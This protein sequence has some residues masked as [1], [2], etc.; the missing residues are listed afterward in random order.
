MEHT[1]TCHS[2]HR[3]S[4]QQCERSHSLDR[5]THTKC[6]REKSCVKH[7]TKIAVEPHRRRLARHERPERHAHCRVR[8][9]GVPVLHVQPLRARLHQLR[10][11]VQE[12]GQ[13]DDKV[14]T[15]RRDPG[16]CGHQQNKSAN[17]GKRAALTKEKKRGDSLLQEY[18]RRGIYFSSQF[19]INSKKSPPG[20]ITGVTVFKLIPKH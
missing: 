6:G 8:D 20:E 14:V 18:F 9:D 11:V 1:Q 19:Q 5:K 4:G 13:D 15:P 16:H 3:S 7:F 12:L 17:L 10:V 2:E